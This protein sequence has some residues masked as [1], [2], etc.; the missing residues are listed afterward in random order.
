MILINTKRLNRRRIKTMLKNLDHTKRFVRVKRN[1]IIIRKYK[2]YS[3]KREKWLITDL[4]IAVLPKLIAEN[5]KELAKINTRISALLYMT[6]YT[7]EY[8]IVEYLWGIYISKYIHPDINKAKDIKS[9]YI[10]SIIDFKQVIKRLKV[11]KVY[12]KPVFDVF[13]HRM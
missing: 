11:H 8:D 12:L 6:Q 5:Q 13:R 4:F 1:G 3:L 10:N 7:K 2:W 9:L